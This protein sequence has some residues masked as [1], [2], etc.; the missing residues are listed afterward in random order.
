MPERR[1][2][3]VGALLAA[4]G[5]ADLVHSGHIGDTFRLSNLVVH[6]LNDRALW[7]QKRQAVVHKLKL[8]SMG[9]WVDCLGESLDIDINAKRSIPI[10]PPPKK[11]ARSH[12]AETMI[13]S[14]ALINGS[15]QVTDVVRR[16]GG[17]GYP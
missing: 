6:T 2:Q 16:K 15:Y 13:A 11:V 1:C 10:Q 7:R 14:F 9:P 5:A 8:D 17:Y 12:Q 4:V 3:T